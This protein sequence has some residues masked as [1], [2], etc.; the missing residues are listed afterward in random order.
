MSASTAELPL[1]DLQTFDDL[2]GFIHRTLCEKENLLVEQFPLSEAPLVRR[3]K[4]CGLQFSLHGPRDV[5]LGAVFA[6]DHNVVYLYDAGGNRYQT[7]K[8][9]QRL[10]A[11]AMSARPDAA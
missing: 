5:R 10:V 3:G 1:A 4:L 11:N 8:L 2:R 9:G 6:S 7:I